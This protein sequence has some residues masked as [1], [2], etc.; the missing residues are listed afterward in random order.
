MF[1]RILRTIAVMLMVLATLA[2]SSIAAQVATPAASPI[3]APGVEAAVLWLIDQQQED[4]S[5]LGFSS[6]PD[7]GTTIDAIITLGAAQ[8]ADIEVGDAIEQALSWVDSEGVASAYVESG[9][10][11][12]AKL[13]LALVAA[14]ADS[15][16][17]GE[18]SPLNLVLEGQ[19]AES[20]VYGSGL[21]DH[22]YA[23]M[24]LAATGSEVPANAISALDTMQADNGGFA[25]DG[26]TDEAMADSNTTAMVVQALVA[27]GAGDSDTVAG[28]IDF[29]ELTVNDQGAGYAIGAEADSNSTAL[30]AQALMAI[31][32]DVTHLITSLNAFQNPTGAYFWM[33]SDV[34]DNLFSTMQV[35]PAGV[36]LTLPVIPGMLELEEAA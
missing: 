10:G 14:D 5:W 29:L 30:V 4:G 2:P 12:A 26:S 1:K 34:S 24:A 31:D 27:V 25:W 19:D 16:E 23:L 20:G 28:A 32:V 9:T 7:A 11:Q 18:I 13:V 21:Y 17:I 33:D 8:E 15:L 3:V 22:S 36:G 35:I 6:E